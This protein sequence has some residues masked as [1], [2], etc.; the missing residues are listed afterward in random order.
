MI[1]FET[2][3]LFSLLKTTKRDKRRKII[4]IKCEYERENYPKVIPK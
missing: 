3:L 1:T 4:V 2:T